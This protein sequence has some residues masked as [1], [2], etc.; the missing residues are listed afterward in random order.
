MIQYVKKQPQRVYTPP[1][2]VSL[3]DMEEPPDYM[4]TCPKCKRRAIDVSELPERLIK[5]RYKCPHCRSIV[6]TPLT[7]VHEDNIQT[8]SFR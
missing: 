6:V 7:A 1:Q 2:S 5:L 3:A 4:I 8:A